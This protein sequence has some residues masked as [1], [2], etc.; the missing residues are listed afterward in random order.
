MP[1]WT[2]RVASEAHYHTITNKRQVR[3]KKK[4]KGENLSSGKKYKYAAEHL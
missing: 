3:E 4:G 1:T 2:N